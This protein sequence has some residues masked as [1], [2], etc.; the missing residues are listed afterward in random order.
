ME[1][2][3]E[4]SAARGAVIW[5]QLSITSLLAKALPQIG[6]G[7]SGPKVHPMDA[8]QLASSEQPCREGLSAPESGPHRQRGVSTTHKDGQGE[9]PAG[10]TWGHLSTN[11]AN[12]SNAY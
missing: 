9:E 5:K 7:F 1:E 2:E 10:R 3:A 6:Q 12:H 8:E 4:S 11:P